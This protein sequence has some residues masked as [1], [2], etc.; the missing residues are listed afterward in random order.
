MNLINTE[1]FIFF[2]RF[3]VRDESAEITEFIKIMS[4]MNVRFRLVIMHE[5]NMSNK[6]EG[7]IYQQ[8]NPDHLEMDHYIRIQNMYDP[9]ELQKKI[10]SS[11]DDQNIKHHFRK[12]NKNAIVILTRGYD[13]I[14]RYANLIHRNKTISSN[15]NEYEKKDIDILIFHE[16]N[17]SINHQKHIASMTK[18][19]HLQFI[20]V[21]NKAFLK[22]NANIKF[23]HDTL[24][25]LWSLG[26]RH[27]CHFWFVDFWNFVSGYS[28]IIRIDEDISVQFLIGPI[29]KNLEN[30]S[31]VSGKWENDIP[32][33][34]KY[35][36]N[37]SNRFFEKNGIHYDPKR[38]PRGPYSNVMGMNIEKLSKNKLFKEYINYIDMTDHI[39]RF[40]WGDLPL[41]GESLLHFFPND[42]MVDPN[43]KY[44][45]GSLNDFVNHKKS[46]VIIEKTTIIKPT[47]RTSSRRL[48]RI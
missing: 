47:F 41:W 26:Y 27:M 30:K 37:T 21:E 18:E 15:M 32:E 13:N 22:K 28:K 45:H 10:A 17:I 5:T 6:I 8:F 38:T 39:Y 36:I 7:V 11:I 12:K 9:S 46:P 2:F 43:I 44:F 14:D 48:Q 35:M 34:V 29:F 23:D 31:V 20:S 1:D 19:L 33:V 16:G 3:S 25:P 40:R 24:N 4:T 42:Y